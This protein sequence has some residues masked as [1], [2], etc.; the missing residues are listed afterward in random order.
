MLCRWLSDQVKCVNVKKQLIM[1][2][3]NQHLRHISG[4]YFVL[5]KWTAPKAAM[6]NRF[7]SPSSGMCGCLWRPLLMRSSLMVISLTNTEVLEI[8]QQD[9]MP[10]PA[11]CPKQYHDIM[12]YCSA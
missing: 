5:I 12:L 11:N 8:I 1:P 4:G 6:Y 9:C 3:T 7:H 2:A 10:C